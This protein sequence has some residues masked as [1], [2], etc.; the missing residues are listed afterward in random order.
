MRIQGMKNL[1]IQVKE[2][3]DDANLQDIWVV[4]EGEDQMDQY[5]TLHSCLFKIKYDTKTQFKTYTV[6]HSVFYQILQQ[7]QG[8]G[9]LGSMI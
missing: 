4:F 6:D 9:I 5:Q 2:I 1:V 3:I 7:D 8:I